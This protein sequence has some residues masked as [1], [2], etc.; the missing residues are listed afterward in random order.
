MLRWRTWAWLTAV[1]ALGPTVLWASPFGPA[2]DLA[3]AGLLLLSYPGWFLYSLA[4]LAPGMALVSRF[5]ISPLWVFP[6]TAVLSSVVI[7]AV[8]HWPPTRWSTVVA[9]FG[10]APVSAGSVFSIPIESWNGYFYSLWPGAFEA[11]I[12]A[13]AF[14][15]AR[16]LFHFDRGRANNRSGEIT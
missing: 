16:R 10:A 9:I 12:A 14:L 13:L 2:R 8:A 1:A 5:G 4:C 15:V 3:H 11:L 6:L 7:G